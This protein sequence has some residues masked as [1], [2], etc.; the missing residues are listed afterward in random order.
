AHSLHNLADTERIVGRLEDARQHA[1]ESLKLYQ[2]L[3]YVLGVGMAMG[4]LGRIAL[5]AGDLPAARRHLEEALRL[6]RQLGN[7]WGES[8]SLKNL[9]ALSLLEGNLEEA[10]RQ[11]CAAA[12]IAM[13]DSSAPLL[14]EIMIICGR[15]LEA[16][17]KAEAALTI[18]A[19]VL[20]QPSA[21]VES[22]TAAQELQS[23]LMGQTG[24]SVVAMALA[25]GATLTLT[26]AA[27]LALNAGA[28]K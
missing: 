18:T 5:A 12:E 15:L 20:T 7:R 4:N 3:D 24:S 25:R 6:R 14:C 26:E 22:R 28:A 11:L 9:G 19:A 23:K 2:E 27:A 1:L 21:E 17:G 8:N 16:E 10:R 13:A